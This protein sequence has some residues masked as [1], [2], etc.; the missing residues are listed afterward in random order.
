MAPKDR[1]SESAILFLMARKPELGPG[2]VR[3]GPADLVFLGFSMIFRTGKIEECQGQKGCRWAW[4]PSGG[5]L[6]P[7]QEGPKIIDGGAGRV[8]VG[9]PPP[10]DPPGA[11]PI[12]M[13]YRDCKTRI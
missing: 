13:I 5:D 11:G 9:V 2:T 1:G 7:P 10:R 6:P 3:G 12:D 4:A 8:Q